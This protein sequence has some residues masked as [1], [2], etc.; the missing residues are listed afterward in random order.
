[1]ALDK[2]DKIGR[3]AVNAELERGIEQAAIDGLSAHLF[4]QG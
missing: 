3:E 4:T 1:M 2:L